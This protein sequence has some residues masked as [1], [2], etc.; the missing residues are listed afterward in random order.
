MVVGE[1]HMDLYSG[2]GVWDHNL[3]FSGYRGLHHGPVLGSFWISWDTGVGEKE[4]D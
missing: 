4:I 2:S 3:Y 1:C